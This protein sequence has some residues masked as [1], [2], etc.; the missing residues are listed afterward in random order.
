LI[1]I[2]P[3]HAAAELSQLLSLMASAAGRR[4]L[5]GLSTPWE[6]ATPQEVFTALQSMR[7]SGAALRIQAM[8]G[9]HDI[10]CVPY[11]CGEESWALMGYPG[12]RAV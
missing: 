1:A 10:V 5:V 12:P 4:W 3:N 7:D 2:L 8:Q 6:E 11:F 9:L